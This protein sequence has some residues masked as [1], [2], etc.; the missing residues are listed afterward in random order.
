MK[1]Y[2]SKDLSEL[3]K[4]ERIKKGITQQEIAEMLNIS[5]ATYNRIESNTSLKIED[6]LIEKIK[7]ILELYDTTNLDDVN[8]PVKAVTIR[9]PY[10]TYKKIDFF[11]F[12]NNYSSLNSALLFILED[13]LT[14]VDLQNNKYE[15]KE[16]I[17]DIILSTYV[18]DMTNL[19]LENDSNRKLLKYL[20]QK[21]EFDANK[22]NE[23]LKQKNIKEK[24][25]KI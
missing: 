23:I 6:E 14:N 4:K 25:A 15:I 24:R 9:I 2:L 13:Y 12:N 1:K 8:N 19:K 17:E 11:R 5:V 16:F 22:E 18:K 20:E 3:F 21:Y 10:K 7:D